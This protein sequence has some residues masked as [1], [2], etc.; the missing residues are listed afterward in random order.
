MASAILC[1]RFP[2]QAACCS[3]EMVCVCLLLCT[4]QSWS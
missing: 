2:L 3:P 1:V 4:G